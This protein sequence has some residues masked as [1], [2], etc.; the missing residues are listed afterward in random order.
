MDARLEQII[1]EL[2]SHDAIGAEPLAEAFHVSTRTIR[3]CINQI[4]EELGETARISMKRGR[5]YVLEILDAKAFE[6]QKRKRA[7]NHIHQVPAT[8]EERVSYLLNDLL[9]RSEWVT[10]EQLAS[11]LYV[12]SATV[13]KDLKQVDRVLEGFGLHLD[14]RPY[15]GLRIEGE[16]FKRRLCLASHMVDGLLRP[17]DGLPQKESLLNSIAECLAAAT[18]EYSL[19]VNSVA[20]HNL[21]VHIAIAILRVKRSCYVPMEPG[22]MKEI[23]TLREYACA[24]RIAVMIQERFGVEFPPEESAYIAIHLAGKQSLYL[25]T[26]G[27]SVIPDEV[28][29]LASTM[30]ERV[31]EAY[32]FDFRND[33]ELRMNLARH[34][35]P[36]GIRLKYQLRLENPMLADIKRRFPLAYSMALDASSTVSDAY[37]SPLSEDEIGYIAMAFELAIERQNGDSAQKN[38]LIVCASGAGSAQLLAYRYRKEFGASLGRVEVCD[39]QRLDAV[40]LRGIDYVFTT[41]PLG[42]SLNVPVCEVGLFL[43]DADVLRVR[44][45]LRSDTNPGGVERFFDRE[46]FIGH[47][48]CESKHEVLRTLVDLIAEHRDIPS[49]FFDLVLE[50]EQSAPT[51]F[52]NLVA[53][54]HPNRAVTDNTFVAV[55]VLARPI[56]WDG[57]EV[58]V[59]FMVSVSR[60]GGAGLKEFYID[61]ADL[62]SSEQAMRLLAERQ[63]YE[64]LLDLLRNTSIL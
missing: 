5:G 50:R 29:S 39:V 63:D 22:Q 2:C 47:L 31:W 43:D 9:C 55:A 3:T 6:D 32:R 36:L 16:E 24:R 44:D 30:I 42:K 14:R 17:E 56:E 40:D 48:V 51:S 33:I 46:L 58:Q 19:Q 38:I 26:D 23:E 53:M 28:W 12:S 15:K 25:E 13:S 59:V 8:P 27:D 60:E 37:G 11:I 34:I 54:P 1:Q 21:I 57:H 49:E 62:L 41:V 20:K 52:G 45:A 18:D 61:M 64:T 7:L 35:A 10:I 4:N